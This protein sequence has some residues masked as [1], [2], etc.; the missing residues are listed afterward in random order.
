MSRK[1]GTVGSA[2]GRK[3]GTDAATA[4]VGLAAEK[5]VDAVVAVAVGQLAGRPAL[6]EAPHES[7]EGVAVQVGAA[8]QFEQGVPAA[9]GSLGFAAAETGVEV[10]IAAA[11]VGNDCSGN[12]RPAA[13]ALA[14]AEQLAVVDSRRCVAAVKC[15]DCTA[16]RS[17]VESLELT[18]EGKA[19]IRLNSETVEQPAGSF[20]IDV[21]S[22]AVVV[23]DPGVGRACSALPRPASD[24]YLRGLLCRV[25]ADCIDPDAS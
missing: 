2:A 22:P 10:R 5:R 18:A 21:D 11:V 8:M 24:S 19:D 23:V 13:T 16:E 12:D 1:L 4:K 20:G 14:I 9:D 17:Q 7:P 6:F 3:V 25:G 15:L